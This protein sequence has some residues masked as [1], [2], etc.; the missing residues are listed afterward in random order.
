VGD[1]RGSVKAIDTVGTEWVSE[2]GRFVA[3]EVA[4]TEKTWPAT[5]VLLALG[6][7]GPEHGGILDQ[8]GVTLDAS[9]PLRGESA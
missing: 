1:E 3:R 9:R 8:L 6:F 4:G 5:L 2:N 7:L